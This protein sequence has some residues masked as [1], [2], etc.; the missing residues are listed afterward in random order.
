MPYF[1][2]ICRDLLVEANTLKD[3]IINT[4]YGI[5]VIPAGTAANRVFERLNNVQVDSILAE[6]RNLYDVIFVDAPPAVVAGDAMVLANKV[7]AA[8][9]VVR[10][11][12]EQR[13]LIARLVHQLNDAQCELL[14]V[15]LNR[16][17]GTAGG[18][19]KKNYAVMAGY[20]SGAS[21]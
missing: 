6:L 14:G 16:P 19:F 15:V 2:A 9:L 8:V 5:D 13:G 21:S 7:D 11:Y 3:T 4:E 18:Y 1:P 12:R 10:A 20:G 17:R